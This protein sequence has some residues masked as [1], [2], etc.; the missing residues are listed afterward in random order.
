MKVTLFDAELATVTAQKEE[1]RYRR[2]YQY[3]LV[4]FLFLM[5]ALKPMQKSDIHDVVQH[6]SV[7]LQIFQISGMSIIGTMIVPSDL[8]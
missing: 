3:Y 5:R 7:V 6:F 2:S 1:A 8:A 4:S